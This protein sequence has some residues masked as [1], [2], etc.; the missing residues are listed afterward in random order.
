MR[1][2]GPK[3]PGIVWPFEIVDAVPKVQ[4]MPGT[5]RPMRSIQRAALGARECLAS[6]RADKT[7][8]I[9]LGIV[10]GWLHARINKT[11]DCQRQH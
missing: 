5:V 8:F 4:V 1:R 9:A 10:A 11:S 7:G 2:E 6:N 3:Y